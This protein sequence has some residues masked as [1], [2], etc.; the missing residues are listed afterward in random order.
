MLNPKDICFPIPTSFMKQILA[1]V[2][3]STFALENFAIARGKNP[4]LTSETVQ[5]SVDS[6]EDPKPISHPSFIVYSGDPRSLNLHSSLTL[7]SGYATTPAPWKTGI[8]ATTFWV[9]EQ[10]T[11]NDPGNLQSAWNPSWLTT[12]KGENP[13]YVALPGNDGDRQLRLENC[14]RQG[15]PPEGR[16]DFT[17][18]AFCRRGLPLSAPDQRA[19]LG[20]PATSTLS[21]YKE[22]SSIQ[23]CRFSVRCWFLFCF[24]SVG[25]WLLTHPLFRLRRA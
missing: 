19:L 5:V 3:L 11:A 6:N 10:P 17:K 18:I 16:G 13:F 9:G 24:F 12:S 7:S 4:A 21:K 22:A 15:D 14:Q 8:T 23:L 20:W 25:H 1:F 2:L